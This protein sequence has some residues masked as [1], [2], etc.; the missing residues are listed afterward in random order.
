MTYSFEDQLQQLKIGKEASDLE[1]YL[2]NVSSKPI[3]KI[4]DDE[5]DE[6]F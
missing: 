6:Q 4:D 2:S 1:S 3:F 5:D